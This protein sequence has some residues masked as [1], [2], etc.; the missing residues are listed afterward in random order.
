MQGKL[1]VF[2]NIE[3]LVAVEDKVYRAKRLANRSLPD[4]LAIGAV[5]GPGQALAKGQG[6]G[7]LQC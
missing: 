1:P 6:R 2:T 5:G 3:V 7:G 4:G